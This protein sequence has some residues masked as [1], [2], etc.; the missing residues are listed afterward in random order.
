MSRRLDVHMLELGD[1]AETLEYLRRDTLAN[2]FLLDMVS[3]RAARPPPGEM[4][5]E[6]A[7]AFRG[8]ELVGVAALRPTIVFDAAMA[9]EVAEAFLPMVDSMSVGLVKCGSAVVD[10]FWQRL[11]GARRRRAIVDRY[12]TAYSL[13]AQDARLAPACPGRET[14]GA[15]VRDLEP[16]VFAA[17]ESLR[18]EGRPDPF[19]GDIKSFRTWVGGRVGR[20][21]VVVA[22]GQVVFVGYGDV[23]SPEGWL[24][25]GIY[26]WPHARRQGFA[27]LGTSDLCQL[28]FEAGAQ[29]V[30][31]AVVEGNEG[32]KAL[33]E[34]LGFKPFGR[35]RTILFH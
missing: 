12:E 4:R 5:T 11:G 3:R 16:L 6:I 20:A 15:G 27:A 26:T 28:A 25:Q 35:L 18:E 34:G 13:D 8:D 24:L 17:R 31:L 21:R 1:T 9:P 29:H 30:Q 22:D 7:L 14:R 33:Y 2:L 10:A 19:A 23:R 32:A